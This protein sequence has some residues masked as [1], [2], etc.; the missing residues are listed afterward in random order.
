MQIIWSQIFVDCSPDP[1][2][3]QSVTTSGGPL[4]S[5]NHEGQRGGGQLTAVGRRGGGVAT[6]DRHGLRD[7]SLLH[8]GAS[9]FSVP[10]LFSRCRHHEERPLLSP[11]VPGGPSPP[12]ATRAS[13]AVVSSPGAGV[14]GF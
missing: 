13:A 11:A 7:L 8:H 6:L 1:F 12:P 14:G 2:P 10:L 9:P 5:P 4:G 3:L